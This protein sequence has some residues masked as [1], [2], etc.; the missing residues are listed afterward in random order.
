MK[1]SDLNKIQIMPFAVKPTKFDPNKQPR[2]VIGFDTETHDGKVTLIADSRGIHAKIRN[3]KELTDY[4][5]KDKYR[6]TVN[7]FFNL[8]Y[9]SNAIIKH[10]PE[11]NFLELIDFNQTIYKGVFLN[12]KPNKEM[13]IGLIRNKKQYNT[14]K[15]YDIANFYKIGSLEETYNKT[16]KNKNKTYKKSMDASRI[17]FEYDNID[18]KA[19]KY[20]IQDARACQELSQSLHEVTSKFCNI[21]TYLSPASISKAVRKR[22]LKREYRFTKSRI[23]EMAL[24]STAGGRIEVSQIGYFPKAYLYDIVSAYPS[25]L[26]NMDSIGSRRIYNNEYMPESIYSFFNVDVI[27]PDDYIIA[28]LKYLLK[29]ANVLGYPVGKLKDCF[30][31]KS[32]LETLMKYDIRF[33]INRAS[34]VMN[35]NEKEPKP[36]SFV[37]ELFEKRIQLKKNNDPRQLPLKLALNS[38]W[39]GTI[40]TNKKY[41]LFESWSDKEENTRGNHL[42]EVYKQ[43]FL[44]KPQTYAGMF[45]NPVYASEVTAQIRNQI[46]EKCFEYQ[47]HVLAIA[48]D[49]IFFDKKINNHFDIE[50][51]K[52]GAWDVSKHMHGVMSGNG[53][54]TFS[55]DDGT[56]IVSKFRGFG[57]INLFD[58]LDHERIQNN[59]N[60]LS[61]IDET[62]KTYLYD[63]KRRCA[64]VVEDNNITY[65][66]K[67]PRKLKESRND[68]NDFN[69]FKYKEKVLSLNFDKKRLWDRKI[70][71]FD[72]LMRN[73]ITSKPIRV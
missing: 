65:I 38:L 71:N 34:H 44:A 15:Y 40:E 69:V 18:E 54:Y 42:R 11:K 19:I 16:F 55:N 3:F 30:I 56:D 47:D 41:D 1:E 68:Y 7:F 4:L 36:F 6:R 27:I 29:K 70:I 58:I 21:N 2:E 45:Y 73:H 5:L 24:R 9:D 20:C 37:K 64:Y 46:F 31:A 50:E 48:T 32:T 52:L 23:Q 25:I 33:K 17:N 43:M 13:R 28:P 35:I 10:L 67:A 49:G 22:Y 63:N 39:G 57:K 12:Q 62:G 8:S 59:S 72:D 51:Y 26:V 14:V 53:I 66:K 61:Y 60:M